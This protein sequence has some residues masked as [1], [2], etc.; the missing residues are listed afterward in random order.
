[1]T[2][3]FSVI[4]PTHNRKATL[5]RCL[6]ALAAQEGGVADCEVIVVDD[7]STD[8][9]ADAVAQHRYPFACTI[10]SVPNAGPGRARNAGAARATGTFLAFT[11][12]DVL[13]GSD[14]LASARRWLAEGNVDVLEGRT[15]REGDRADIRRF[16]PEPSPSFIPCNLFVRRAVFEQLGGYDDAFFDRKTGLYFRED[17]DLGFRLLSAGYHAVL[18]GDVVVEHPLQ[19]PDLASSLRHVR[20][21]Q[22]DPLLYR[23]HPGP[24]RSMIEV[25]S[26]GGMVLHRPLHYACLMYAALLAAAV[27]GA[28]LALPWVVPAALA[29]LFTCSWLVRFK[30]QSMRALRLYRLDETAGFAVLPAVYLASV[31]KGCF[32]F[33]SFGLWL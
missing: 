29:G 3:L 6:D 31:V 10:C 33:R 2:P 19:F 23:K 12:D 16:E 26:I 27:A 5:E 15:V 24:Y 8:G 30:Y 17:A 25:K 11:E 7:G 1:M 14:W 9:T 32:R 4:I 28:F 13:P 21:Y 22:F 20:R 18:A